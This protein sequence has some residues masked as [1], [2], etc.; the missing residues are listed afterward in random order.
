MTP[1][2]KIISF[3]LIIPRA[4][5]SEMWN[6]SG[7]KI[8]DIQITYLY[9]QALDWDLNFT[10]FFKKCFMFFM[11]EAW[12][13]WVEDT[14]LSSLCTVGPGDWPGAD[15]AVT[16][17]WP[18]HGL[19]YFIYRWGSWTLRMNSII[20]G[21]FTETKTESHGSLKTVS[22]FLLMYRELWNWCT[23][24]LKIKYMENMQYVPKLVFL[25]YK[26]FYFYAF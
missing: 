10:Y 22:V 16:V 7:P 15:E 11:Y 12:T 23:L 5:N 17:P 25:S 6:T 3:G 21:H 1:T 2:I 9:V 20:P 26:L 8:T 19:L 14:S 4:T 13:A 24:N 18:S